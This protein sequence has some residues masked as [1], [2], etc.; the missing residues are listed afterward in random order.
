MRWLI[1]IALL[2]PS[3]AYSQAIFGQSVSLPSNNV[4]YAPSF[5]GATFDVKVN[6]CLAV[7]ITTSGTCDAR[8]L[9]GAQSM[10][11]N[12][13]VGD[14]THPV[15]LLLPTSVIT[16]ASGKQF[17]YDSFSH[18]EGTGR[19][20]TSPSRGTL[21]TGN[22]AV[23]AFVPADEGDL[24][25]AVDSPYIGHLTATNNN[26]GVGIEIGGV[27]GSGN[28]D[29]QKGVFEDVDVH[30]DSIGVSVAGPN[31]CTCYNHLRDIYASGATYG[32]KVTGPGVASNIFGEGGVYSGSAIGL[33]DSGNLDVYIKPDV[34]STP[35][36]GIELAGTRALIID[37]YEEGN[38]I[39]IIDSGAQWNMIIGTGDVRYTDNS[40]NTNN[41][42]WGP[43]NAPV[44]IG[45]QSGYLFGSFSMGVDA[46][47]TAASLFIGGSP[48][49]YI[50]LLSLG[51][52]QSVYGRYKH[53]GAK[54]GELTDFSGIDSRG[55]ITQVALAN[56]GSPTITNVGA[57]GSTTYTYFV[58]CHDRNG[59]VTLPSAAGTTTTGNATLDLTNYNT[60]SWT[61]IDGCFQWDVLQTDTAHSIALNQNPGF[62]VGT[63]TLA[64]KDQGGASSAYT[65]PTR[66]TTGDTLLA[67]E[68]GL[69]KESGAPSDTAGAGKCRMFSVAGTNAGTCKIQA[70]CGTS[71]TPVTV[72]DNI[73]AGC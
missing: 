33:Y 68:F 54:F 66:N 16:R 63:S 34:E 47:N 73:G 9:T 6:A 39:D 48:Y 26:T 17:I 8:G 2:L 31:G 41:F 10:A 30:S 58:V 36:H 28:T 13:V 50:E 38:G 4:Q 72:L 53:L 14:G 25:H 69:T 43:T 3:R 15:A 52:D 70:I 42:K 46:V 55:R 32:V 11:A 37:P 57:A 40:G 56:P 60:V 44:S 51:T 59:G 5:A 7:A 12:I 62:A 21:I 45:A 35:T 29:V 20:G 23:A 22:D 71:A 18:I 67:G 1:L 64:Y 49:D 24:G 19:G 61:A 27:T 65:A